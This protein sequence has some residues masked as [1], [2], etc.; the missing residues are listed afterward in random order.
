MDVV[1]Q[2]ILDTVFLETDMPLV[3]NIRHPNP[4]PW[5][6]IM[7]DIRDALLSEKDLTPTALPLIPFQEWVSEMEG[8]DDSSDNVV[9]HADFARHKS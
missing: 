9:S 1:A 2:V 5:S 6:T 7:M 3:V 8:F 4:V